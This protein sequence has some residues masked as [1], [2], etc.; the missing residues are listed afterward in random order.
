[1]AVASRPPRRRVSGILLLDKPLGLSSNEALQ[2]LKRLYGADKAGHTGSLD[3]LATGMLPICFGEATK[4]SGVLLDSDKAYV[5]RVRLGERTATG[6]AEGEVVAR[7]D[8]SGVTAAAIERAMAG[9]IGTYAQVPPMYSALKRD[10]RPLYALARE[11]LSVERAPRPVRIVELRLLQLD[12]REFEMRLHCSKGT[13]VRTLAEDLAATLGQQAHLRALRRVGVAPFWDE[14][15]HTW[16]ALE[17]LAG[18]L[19][20]LDGLLLSPAQALRHWPSV[21][22]DA[23]QA[24]AFGRGQALRIDGLS[25]AG[26]LAVLDAE[27][28]L[29]GIAECDAG[30]RLRPQRCLLPAPRL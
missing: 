27:G 10:G 3:P 13:Y 15:M 9:F 21:R 22:L 14:P 11:G 6:D 26:R 2:K 20:A 19:A 23:A 17:A 1:M 5:A 24:A 16:T 7:S 18:D 12:G 25:P 4:L 29:L 28:A 8:P 30:G